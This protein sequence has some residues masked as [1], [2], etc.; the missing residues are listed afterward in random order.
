MP[1][2][3][4]LLLCGNHN[5]K[6]PTFDLMVGD[7]T[8]EDGVWIGARAS[9]GPGVTYGSHSVPAMASIATNN[10]EAW[11]IHRGNPAEASHSAT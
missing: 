2:Q 1:S 4:A 9:V 10:L 6:K 8:L 11:T 3:G 7:I 5:D